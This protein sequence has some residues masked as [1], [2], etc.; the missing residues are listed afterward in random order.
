MLKNI[1]SLPII[2]EPQA[3]EFNAMLLKIPTAFFTGIQQL[4][5]GKWLRGKPW[6][7]LCEGPACI[8]GIA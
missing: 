2:T 3:R 1:L 8:L 7:C 5:L 6:P 4:R